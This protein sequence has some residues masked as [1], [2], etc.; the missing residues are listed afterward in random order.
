MMKYKLFLD[1]NRRVKDVTWVTL[2]NGPWVVARSYEDFIF[3]VAQYGV[4]EFVTYDCDLC[5]EHYRAFFA[6]GQHYVKKYVDFETKCGIDCVNFLLDYCHA[7]K[8]NHPPF[9]IH[10][11]NHYAAEHMFKLIS[12]FNNNRL[13]D[14]PKFMYKNPTIPPYVIHDE[15]KISGFFGE[16]RFLS[17]FWPV[18]VVYEDVTY[19]SVEV[20]YQAA[21]SEDKG[22]R[23]KFEEA[24]SA[25]AKSLGRQIT[26]R[27]DWD[28]VKEQIMLALLTAKFQDN[29]LQEKLKA[30]GEKELI[31]ANGWKDSFWGVAYKY[32][33]GTETYDEVG[34]KN[35]LGKLLMTVRKDL[36]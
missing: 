32:N 33:F 3:L 4:P 12:N 18:P 11:K 34:G 10:T 16:Y 6:L 24:T 35:I 20:A 5:V 21:K 19:P 7:K 13:L 23:K 8:E 27:P 25:E 15:T 14:L 28:L 22:E 17:N 29:I 1:D 2:P 30:T 31:E 9:I 36:K 26:I